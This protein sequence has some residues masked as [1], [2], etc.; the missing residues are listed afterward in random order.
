[1][2]KHLDITGILA[3]FK[4]RPSGSFGKYPTTS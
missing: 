3:L 1:L 2:W 4:T